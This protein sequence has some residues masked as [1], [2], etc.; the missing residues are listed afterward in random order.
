VKSRCWTN[1][2]LGRGIL[3]LRGFQRF[4]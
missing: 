1:W 2:F 3:K 4:R